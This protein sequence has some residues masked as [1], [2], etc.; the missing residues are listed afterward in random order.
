MLEISWGKPDLSEWQ[1]VSLVTPLR[2]G[3]RPRIINLYNQVC[4]HVLL[5]G[6]DTVIKI[7]NSVEGSRHA[8]VTATLWVM[9]ADGK[10]QLAEGAD[11]KRE[12]QRI[13]RYVADPR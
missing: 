10:W 13:V 4:C 9:A 1:S 7:A 6:R 2:L 5:G 12:L 8:P 3:Y 11:P